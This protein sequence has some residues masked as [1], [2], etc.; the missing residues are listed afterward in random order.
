M[1]DYRLR[2]K[3]RVALIATCIVAGQL[4]S[5]AAGITCDS[6]KIIQHIPGRRVAEHIGA[7]VPQRAS[8]RLAMVAQLVC[9][10]LRWHIGIRRHAIGMRGHLWAYAAGPAGFCRQMVHAVHRCPCLLPRL[11]HEVRRL[12][13]HQAAIP[14]SS[15]RFAMERRGDEPK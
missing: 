15:C 3:L 13:H 8:H 10:R 5:F 6:A 2:R 12:R 4:S 7:D 14:R 9:Q 1:K 11:W